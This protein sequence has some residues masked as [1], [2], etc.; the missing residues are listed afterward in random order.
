VGVKVEKIVLYHGSERIVEKPEF[1][2]GVANND[3]GVGF[4]ATKEEEIAKE[5]ACG[6][7]DDGYV[8]IYSISLDGLR[9]FDITKEKNSSLVW[10]ARLL[11]NRRLRIGDAKQRTARDFI[12]E[13]YLPDL[14]SYDV[15]VGTRGDD[16]YFSFARAFLDGEISLGQIDKMLATDKLSLQYALVSDKAIKSL[17][18]SD[19]LVEDGS[20][21]YYKRKARDKSLRESVTSFVEK[22]P[23]YISDIMER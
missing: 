18:F 9:V 8:N 10:L 16:S 14:S 15:I 22:S 1:L 2:R 3:F 4:Y 13:N 20:D 6:D 23:K 17:R 11:K 21:C 7:G 19:V 5:W 12:V